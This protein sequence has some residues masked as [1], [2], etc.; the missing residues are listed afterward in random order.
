MPGFSADPGGT[1]GTNCNT[2]RSVSATEKETA[3]A[4]AAT[5]IGNI[6]VTDTRSQI[7]FHLQSYFANWRPVF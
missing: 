2:I 6:H 1:A 3:A 4:G 7:F 5:L